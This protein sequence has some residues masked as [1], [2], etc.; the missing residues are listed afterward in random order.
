MLR[1][2][3]PA[4]LVAL[5]ALG[6]LHPLAAQAGPG[7]QGRII[8]VIVDA[9][10]GHP[11]AIADVAAEAASAGAHATM[12]ASAGTDGR[13]A[14]ERVA[15]G[16]YHV[17]V[18]ALGYTPRVLT[19][20]VT[21]TAPVADL[22]TIRLTTAAIQLDRV[23]VS[24][25]R[26]RIVNLAPDKSTYTV[27]DMPTTQGG[28][29]LDV[30]RN[31]PSVDVDID[32][33]VSLRGDAG[34][35]VQ[36]NGRKS[37]L[38]AAQLGTF[39][40]QL[41]A[42]MVAK[43][44]VTTNPSARDNPEG[45]A[46]IIN[47]VLKKDADAGLSGGVTATGGTTGRA[48]VGGNLGYQAGKVTLFGS[49]GWLHDNRPRYETVSRVNYYTDP[50]TYLDEVRNRTEHPLANTFTASAAYKVTSHDA[51]STDLFYSTRQEPGTNSILYRN[52]DGSGAVTGLSRR[53]S[54][55]TN[56]EFYLQGAAEYDHRFTADGHTLKAQ[57]RIERGRE[58]GPDAFATEALDS[59]GAVSGGVARETQTGYEHPAQ[60]VAQLDYARPIGS[61]LRIEAGYKGTLQ[62]FHTTL[63]TRVLDTA[64]AAFVQDTTRS[65]NYTYDERV[66]ALY[67]MGTGQLG[68][69]EL[70]GGVRVERARTTF[71]LLRRG[72][73]VSNPYDSF[74]PSGLVAYD[75]DAVHQVKLS[76]STRIRRPDDT[77]LI[78]PTPHYADPLNLSV[79]NPHL[80]PEYIRSLELGFQ[81]ET[82]R[83]TVQ[84]TPFYRHT[85]NAVRRIRSIDTA[86][87]TTTTFA[88]VATTD[89]YGTDAT[90]ALHGGRLS[91]YLG[92]SAYRQ[93]SN[94]GN[95][96]A[97]L[98]VRTFGWTAR[99]NATLRVTNAVDMQ[100]LVYYRGPQTVEQGRVSGQARVNLAGRA[101]LM[102]DRLSLTLRLV[103]P[104]G[105]DHERFT[106]IDPSF[107]QVSERGRHQRGVLIGL[108]WNFGHPPKGAG[109]DD[110]GGLG[111]DTGP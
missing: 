75:I 41:P 13:F 100:A 1:R 84:V 16:S 82:D 12:R 20:V 31:V 48:E 69:F 104:F 14:I 15:T 24:S 17:R 26:D 56:H 10:T 93:V 89:A 107:R 49:Y 111:G 45:T 42:D 9:A 74:F 62:R 37:P 99:T 18:R 44:E 86:G 19:A 58:G 53:T 27:R 91:G 67:A 94:A 61:V 50:L 70:Q 3:L 6:A 90:L 96:I 73:S 106:T 55:G 23:V 105:T 109:R 36:I 102:D 87:V 51:L 22:D 43:V 7:R 79:G 98:T 33:V 11:L 63:D 30:L 5:A 108:S 8:G 76:Y 103:D 88:N 68:K 46:G 95:V 71:A 72:T 60:Y 29:A 35:V 39:L 80:Q 52:L 59:T 66:N 38:T 40:A 92:A 65:S 57:A 28:S 25:E 81:R 64:Q 85:L 97:G 47:V 4:L 34:V 54:V 78:D 83:A 21:A 101:K 110:T 2:F 77:D 32:N